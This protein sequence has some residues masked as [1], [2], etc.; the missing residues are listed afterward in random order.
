VSN[1]AEL[2]SD[3]GK[4]NVVDVLK[5]I[6]SG[7]NTLSDIIFELK[8]Q[9]STAG[10]AIKALVSHGLIIEAEKGARGKKIY[11]ITP[12]GRE[13]ITKLGEMEAIIEKYE[14]KIENSRK[15]GRE[16]VFR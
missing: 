4:S 9:P 11:T 8:I 1:L 13:I 10:R 12:Y 14:I 15:E 16:V 7:K 6:N 3:L 2:L 5:A